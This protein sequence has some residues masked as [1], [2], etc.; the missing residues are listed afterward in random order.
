MNANAHAT[1]ETVTSKDGTTISFERAGSGPAVVLVCGG[2][3]DRWSN[4]GLAG[5]LSATNTVFN[6]DRRGRGDSGDTLPFA[7]EREIEDIAAVVEATG[8]PAGLYGTSSGGALALHAAAALGS[9]VRKLALWEVPYFADPAQRPPLDTVEQYRKR[10]D[11]GHP[12]EAV[13]YFMAEVVRLP[14]EFVE[15]A[16][17]QPFFAGQVKIAHTLVYDGLAMGDYRIPTD[18]AASVTAP[19]LVL[20][21]GADFPAMIES[22]KALAA[23]IPNATFR[24]LEGQGHNVDP[25]VIGAAL[26]EFFVA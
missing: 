4:A 14:K 17:T 2:S 11:A 22:A 3:T 21:G 18:V 23:A 8:G 10:L 25:A 13:E 16:K 1:L 24:H 26:A 20:A 7:V 6:F 15:F 12:E 5:V 19:T 9:Q